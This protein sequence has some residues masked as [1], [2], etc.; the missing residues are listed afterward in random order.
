MVWLSVIVIILT[1]SVSARRL[2]ER[3]ARD[4]RM[5]RHEADWPINIM[6]RV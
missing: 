2:Y 3:L 4:Q 5:N 1:P 6:N